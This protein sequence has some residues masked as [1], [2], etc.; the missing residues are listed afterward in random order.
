M[1]NLDKLVFL[2][3]TNK[4]FTKFSNSDFYS[5][6]KLLSESEED[7]FYKLAEEI[8]AIWNNL[9][10]PRNLTMNKIYNS[11]DEYRE[12]IQVSPRITKI[13]SDFNLD[14]KDSMS[15]EVKKSIIAVLGK[16]F[17]DK[18]FSQ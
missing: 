11:F 13:M 7:E 18:T 12:E 9:N 5:T 16:D 8:H 15:D 6:L 10:A 4:Q 3:I 14:L 1:D 17:F 2:E